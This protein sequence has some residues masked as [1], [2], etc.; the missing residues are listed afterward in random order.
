MKVPNVI[1][2]IAPIAIV[3]VSVIIYV[4]GRQ[5]PK[6]NQLAPVGIA[7]EQTCLSDSEISKALHTLSDGHPYE[8]QQKAVAFLKASAEFSPACRKQVVARLMSAMNQPKP[9]LPRDTPQINIWHY[10]PRLLGELKAVES[11]DLLVANFQL[12]DESWFPLIHDSAV[13]GIIEM[14]EVALP[15]MQAVLREYQNPATRQFAVFCVAMIGG[16]SAEKILQDALPSESD[17]CN[18]AC[19]RATLKSFKNKRRP[20]HISDVGR[21]EW[22]STFMCNGK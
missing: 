8:D 1:P 2:R 3:V 7:S 15:K 21:T 6:T 9:D 5:S 17:V 22:L 13:S 10:G 20:Q 4:I 16:P 12:H 14:G 19:I 11:L 18:S